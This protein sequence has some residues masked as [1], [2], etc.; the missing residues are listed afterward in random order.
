MKKGRV[1]ID[2]VWAK[3]PTQPTSKAWSSKLVA[4]PRP[5]RA[6]ER[7]VVMVGGEFFAAEGGRVRDY[8]GGVTFSVAV[9]CLM[10]ASCGLIFGYDIGVTGALDLCWLALG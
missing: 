6:H 7:R 8:S 3:V 9:T 1:H 2:D 5:A 10:A 4:R